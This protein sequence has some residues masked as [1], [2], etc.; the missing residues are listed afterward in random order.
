MVVQGEGIVRFWKVM[1]GEG[2]LSFCK[3]CRNTESEEDSAGL[4]GY[5]GRRG[6]D[7]NIKKRSQHITVTV[8]LLYWFV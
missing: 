2:L 4:G 8:Y 3:G 6:C 1:R 5:A 7:N